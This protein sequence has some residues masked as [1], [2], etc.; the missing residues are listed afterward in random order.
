[1]GPGRVVKVEKSFSRGAPERKYLKQANYIVIEHPQG[2]HT[3]YSHLEREG[4]L[5]NVG[6][7]VQQ[8]Q[9]IARVGCSGYCQSEHLHIEGF[10]REKNLRRSFPIA[11]INRQ[12]QTKRYF[13]VG[14]ELFSRCAN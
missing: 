12:G 6:D 5:V 8:G 4:L 10:M 13:K 7:R 9:V 3:L 11:I 14:E 2:V 1:M